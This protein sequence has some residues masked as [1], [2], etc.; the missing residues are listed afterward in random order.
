MP[1]EGPSTLVAEA[2]LLR[3]ADGALKVG[4]A[5]LALELVDQHATSYPGGVLV[6]EREAE[7]VLVLCGL[8]RADDARIAASAFLRDYPRSTQ[9]A[10]VR[11][12]CGSP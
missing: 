11:G 3:R 12:A 1:A 2:G 7:R 8:G 5:A 9:A 6:E 10:R 4:N